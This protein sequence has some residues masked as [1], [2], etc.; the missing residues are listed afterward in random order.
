MGGSVKLERGTLW[1]N[2]IAWPVS[3]KN[4]LGHHCGS[5]GEGWR[6]KERLAVCFR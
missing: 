6:E 4:I 1:L 2:K 3:C 5:E